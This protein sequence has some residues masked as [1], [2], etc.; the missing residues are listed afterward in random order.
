ML[1]EYLKTLD[2]GWFEVSEAFKGLADE[3]VWKRPAPVLLS[4]GDLAGHIAHWEAVRLAGDGLQHPDLEQSKVKSPLID[5][6]FR[7]YP[8]T[9][10]TPPSEE[11][12]TMTAE[13]VHKEMVRVHQES[14][15]HFRAL[16]PDLESAPP[17]IEGHW[18]YGEFLRYLTFHVS[19]HTGQMYSARHLL[20]E[21]TP[22]N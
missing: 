1:E 8:T 11:H 3:N 17:G 4:I 21:E 16:N 2:L 6:R 9:I 7:Y 22:D 13:Q 5:E 12:L 19:Y 14:V 18:T 10:A 15:A 20:G